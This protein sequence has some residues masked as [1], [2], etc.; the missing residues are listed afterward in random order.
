[1]DQ[2]LRLDMDICLGA[3][4]TSA[5]SY[6]SGNNAPL[7]LTTSGLLRVDASGTPIS[8]TVTVNQGT[9]P[10]TISG[11]V[12][13]NQGGTWLVGR[14][15]T[16]SNGSDSVSAVQSGTWTVQ[17]GSPPWSVSQSGTWNI[18]N[19]TGT[20]SLPTGAATEATLAKLTLTQGSTTSGQ[21]GPLVQGAVT[22]ADPT[23]TTGQTS[24]LSLST[25]GRLRVNST[26]NVA[27][28]ATDSGNPVKV[29]AIYNSSPTTFTSGQRSDAQ[30]DSTGSLYVNASGR[31]QTYSAV[32]TAFTLAATATDAF[33][34][35]GS[36]T[37]TIKVKRISISGTNTGNTNALFLL[38]KR[39]TADTGGTSSTLTAVPSDSNN[40]AATASVKSYTANPTLG[41]TVGTVRGSYLFM[42]A[43]A[44]TNVVSRMD[45]D[46]TQEGA[47]P[48]ILRGTGEVLAVNMNGAT[49]TG[50]TVL[51]ISVTWVEE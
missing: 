20:I 11:T 38:V 47:Q 13:A 42:P 8:G 31:E 48:L 21:S 9:S 32:G 17:Q 14:T 41:T 6:V 46:F 15:W 36:G 51:T 50:T 43:L 35:T 29:G 10:W 33:T 5:P 45:F 40:A 18:N 34:I 16:L 44:S 24:P 25:A 26:G 27:S 1:M 39:S 4:T 2:F 3:V 30:S 7:S 12:T 19:I 37:K 22:T 49:I 28:G 23:Y